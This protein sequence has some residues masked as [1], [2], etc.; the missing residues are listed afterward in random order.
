M[1]DPG[2]PTMK[3]LLASAMAT[4]LKLASDGSLPLAVR[5]FA[6]LLDCALAVAVVVYVYS[7][8]RSSGSK[9]GRSRKKS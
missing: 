8:A 9:R 2:A 3:L 1:Y 4:V 7:I 6:A 5:S